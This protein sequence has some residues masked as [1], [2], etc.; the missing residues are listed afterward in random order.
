MQRIL[1]R[2]KLKQSINIRVVFLGLSQLFRIF[3]HLKTFGS[4]RVFLLLYESCVSIQF[5]KHATLYDV[6]EHEKVFRENE[7]KPNVLVLRHSKFLKLDRN[8]SNAVLLL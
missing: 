2:M 7:A 6:A 3:E 5:L 8:T 4:L 1:P